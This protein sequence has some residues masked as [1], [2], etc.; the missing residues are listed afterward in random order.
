MAQATTIPIRRRR[1]STVALLAVGYS[2]YYLCRS[3]LSVAM[4][5]IADDLAASGMSPADA[6]SALG[7][8]ASVG[9]FAYALG[10]FFSGPLADRVGGR[11][12][13]LGGMAGAIGF[14]LLFMLGAGAGLVPCGMGRQ[15]PGAVDG[16]G[17]D[18]QDHRPV[19]PALV[20]RVG[21]GRRQPQLSLRGRPGP[22]VPRGPD[23]ARPRLAGF[24]RGLGRGPGADLPGL[25]G[26]PPGIAGGRGPGG[27]PRLHRGRNRDGAGLLGRLLGNPAFW[28]VCGLSL[29]VT[30][31]RETFNTWT[32]TYFVEGVGLSKAAAA[33]ASGLFPLAG[34]ASVLLAGW[35]SDRLGRLGRGT[36]LLTGLA[37]A[38]GA[39]VALGLIDFGGSAIAPVALVTAV[40]FFLIGPYSYLAGAIAL[41]FGGRKGGA[42]ASGLID[43][44][45]YL[46]G[47]LAGRGMADL[48]VSRGWSGAFLVLA[49]V[50]ACSSLAVGRVDLRPE[51]TIAPAG[52]PDRDGRERAARMTIADEVMALLAG[53]G[54]NAYLGEPVSQAE[55]A[56]Q[57]ARLAEA[58]GASDAL[59][60]SALL[61]DV[62]HLVLGS[63]EDVA[64]RGIDAR[65]ED[66]GAAWLAAHF[67]PEVAGP[68]RL[69]VEAKRYLCAVDPG[70]L[71]GLSAASKK[72]LALQG[73]PMSPS[74]AARFE[75]D[76]A[77]EAAVR[78]RRWDDEAKVPGLD[79]PGPEH[80]RTRIESA[81][82][83]KG[84]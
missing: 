3:N 82:R 78:L 34:G 19:V 74:E 58:A 29:G 73:G 81:A 66:A 35:A 61:H 80:Y 77:H 43:G 17:G 26:L 31:L 41:D 38:A 46:G 54:R 21:D 59:V 4:P 15:P 6:K 16:L 67:G 40:A 51:R 25:H 84:S 53:P 13:F 64:D 20:L 68:A 83:V 70:Y 72:S 1:I 42:T 65:H 11:W 36:I 39:L 49:G 2:G 30:L 44:I 47:V 69:H 22:V 63:P 23:R 57:A 48:A 45:G 5:M 10:K 60:V 50:A 32:P 62:G 37:T 71:D 55:H 7:S 76:P 12:N 27:S 18:G 8:V 9:I 52:C 33:R 24:V 79:V 28:I 75:R 56:L 14:T